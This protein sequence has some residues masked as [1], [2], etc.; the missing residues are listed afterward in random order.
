MST[1]RIMNR[2]VRGQVSPIPESSLSVHRSIAVSMD[3]LVSI[4]VVSAEEATVA[5]AT[6]RALSWF[7][8]VEQACSRF[9]A[10]S[11][12]RRLIGSVGKPVPVSPVLFEAVRFAT[13]LARLTDGAFDPTIGQLLEAKG[14]DRHYATGE[15]VRSPV[16]PGRRVSYRDIRL[17]PARRT[18]TLRRPLVLDLGA[19]AKGLAIDL[20]A[21]ELSAFDDFCIDAGGDIFARRRNGRGRPWRIGVRDPRS[22]DAVAYVVEASGEAVCTSGDYERRTVDGLEHHL[23][24]P[25]TGR[26]ARALASVTVVAPT[27]MA[28]DGLATAAFILG[29]ARG[30]QLLEREAVG[31]VLIA[32]SGDVYTTRGLPTSRAAERESA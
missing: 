17:D 24:D 22:L 29:P 7:A 6:Q 16:P 14:F 5:T 11:E 8:V 4:E 2:A 26:S 31:G 13:A 25:R 15:R 10:A 32:P 28:A 9:D 18:I 3:T 1:R 23:V 30:L 12:V 27:A 21:R 20:A 19:V